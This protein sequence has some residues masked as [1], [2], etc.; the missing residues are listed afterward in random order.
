[1]V[2]NDGA[3]AAEHEGGRENGQFE[4]SGSTCRNACEMTPSPIEHERREAMGQASSIKPG[5]DAAAPARAA[6]R[7]LRERLND[8]AS[9]QLLLGVLAT[10]S[11]GIFW[12]FSG[13]SASFLF[14]NYHVDTVWLLSIR[15]LLAGALFMMVILLRDRTR[16]MQLLKNPHDLGAMAVFTFMGVFINSFTYLLA[17]RFTNAGTATVMQCLQLVIVMCGTKAERKW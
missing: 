9:R 6:R 3:I 17:V 11:G 4:H 12:G 8:R 16:F 14:D 13:T 7:S 10:L 1:M 5:S 15:Q 2:D